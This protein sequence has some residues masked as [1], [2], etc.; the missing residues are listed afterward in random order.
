MLS[1]TQSWKQSTWFSESNKFRNTKRAKKPSLGVGKSL[2]PSSPAFYSVSLLYCANPK[3]M[4]TLIWLL[5]PSCVC[6][7]LYKQAH[8]WLIFLF[9]YWTM[10]TPSL[11]LLFT[12]YYSELETQSHD[13]VKARNPGIC[14]SRKN[15]Y[16]H[17]ERSLEIPRGRGGLKA[18]FLEALYENKPEFPGGGGGAQNKKPSMGGIWILIFL[19]LHNTKNRKKAQFGVGFTTPAHIPC[20]LLSTFKPRTHSLVL[21]ASKLL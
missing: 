6:I 3:T 12:L 15:P 4:N 9:L 17:Q 5:T 8:H 20:L 13:C 7:R 10:C 11:N 19:E 1:I 14:S 21:F 16:P 2:Q 18:K